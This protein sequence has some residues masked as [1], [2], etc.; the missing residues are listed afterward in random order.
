MMSIGL[1]ARIMRPGRVAAIR[2][3]LNYVSRFDDV[4]IAERN[5]IAF[6]FARRFAPE[7]AWN[8]PAE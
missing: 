7:G 2:R 8:W 3:F 4:W 5:E 6:D 1:H